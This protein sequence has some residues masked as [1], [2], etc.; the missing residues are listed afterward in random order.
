MSRLDGRWASVTCDE[1]GGPQA[2]RL[3]GEQGPLP[4][5][6]VLRHW[7]EWIG[8]LDGEPERD[9]WHVDTPLGGCE[10]HHLRRPCEGGAGDDETGPGAWVLFRWDD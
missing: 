5:R 6:A 10:L 4:V 7:R 2:I 3:R 1:Q 8:A 9:I